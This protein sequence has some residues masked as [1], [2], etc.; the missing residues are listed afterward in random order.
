MFGCFERR[1]TKPTC[2]N[3]FKP[4]LKH[5]I[6]VSHT[7][8][9]FFRGCACDF[10]AS[11]FVFIPN[12]VSMTRRYGF[13]VSVMQILQLGP[14]SLAA[15]AAMT[16][17]TLAREKSRR[18]IEPVV[19]WSPPNVVVVLLVLSLCSD[20]GPPNPPKVVVGLLVSLQ[21]KGKR[22]NKGA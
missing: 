22:R 8:Q 19:C 7:F 14:G 17:S 15:A 5:L 11:S 6:C 20:L 18:T 4:V 3:T 9:P 21:K 10:S 2:S 12:N 16:F 1:P 13:K